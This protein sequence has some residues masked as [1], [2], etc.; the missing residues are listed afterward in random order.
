MNVKFN[1]IDGGTIEYRNL[2]VLA[3]KGGVV[4]VISNL[5]GVFDIDFN[6]GLV[7]AFIKGKGYTKIGI[8]P[9]QI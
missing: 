6:N 8:N 5:H 7:Y 3:N 2:T 9:T 1:L 4:R